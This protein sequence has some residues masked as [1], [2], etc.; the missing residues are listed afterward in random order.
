MSPPPTPPVPPVDAFLPQPTATAA[1][2]NPV[3]ATRTRRGRSKQLFSIVS[4]RYARI[5]VITFGV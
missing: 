3:K 1:A 5:D 2:S 4:D